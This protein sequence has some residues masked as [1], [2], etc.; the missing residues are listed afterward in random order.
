MSVVASEQN[1]KT[2][3]YGNKP[4]ILFIDEISLF[5]RHELELLSK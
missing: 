5:A 2:V 4:T 1:I 3:N